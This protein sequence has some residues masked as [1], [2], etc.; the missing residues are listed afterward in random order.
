MNYSVY[1]P[2]NGKIIKCLTVSNCEPNESFFI[3]GHWDANQYYV[4]NGVAVELP[5]K[6]DN[7]L[8]A[9]DFD[10]VSHSWVVNDLLSGIQVRAERT[11]LLRDVDQV[12]PVR[13]A[14]LATDQQQELATYRQALLAVPQ[15]SGFPQ[16]VTWPVKPT[17]L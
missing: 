11:R 7:S 10:F 4:N 6:P 9:Y 17:W 2:A 8:L 12:T 5:P 3:S 15:Q 14:S 16:T 13:Y 1:D